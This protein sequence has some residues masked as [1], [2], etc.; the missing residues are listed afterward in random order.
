MASISWS[1][2]NGRSSQI[3]RYDEKLGRWT[4]RHTHK[5]HTDTQTQHRHTQ[6]QVN[7][8]SLDKL[9]DYCAEFLVHGVDVEGK[10]PFH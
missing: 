4:H 9:S 3:S 5:S 6:A 1:Q 8:E 7:K 2:T 10:V